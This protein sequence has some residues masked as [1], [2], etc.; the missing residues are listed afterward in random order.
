MNDEL[1]TQQII[2]ERSIDTRD[3]PTRPAKPP[4][5]VQWAA[6]GIRFFPLLLS[7]A[8]IV[9]VASEWDWWLGSG[10][11]QT[12]DDAYLQADVTPLAAKVAGFVRL[13]PVLDFQKMKASDLLQTLARVREQPNC[14]PTRR[15]PRPMSCPSSTASR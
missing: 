5:A 7:G 4:G 12:T 8:L 11:C 3:L 14:S 15:A 10:T 6:I 2:L 9:F 1:A 13:I